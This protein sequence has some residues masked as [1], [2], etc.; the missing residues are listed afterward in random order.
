MGTAI[1]YEPTIL[2]T[3]ARNNTPASTGTAI[4]IRPSRKAAQDTTVATTT[5][6]KPATRLF[7]PNAATHPSAETQK[8][9]SNTLT[10]NMTRNVFRGDCM[11]TN[12][13]VEKPSVHLAAPERKRQS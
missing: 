4:A 10:L 13:A 8:A 6:T 3:S 11:N 5:A 1:K 9:V 2:G 12:E 7:S